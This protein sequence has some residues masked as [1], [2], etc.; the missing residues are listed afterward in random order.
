MKRRLVL[1]IFLSSTLALLSCS[2]QRL[3]REYGSRVAPAYLTHRNSS[4]S[5]ALMA[6]GKISLSGNVAVDGLQSFQGKDSE[7]FLHTN[8]PQAEAI[9]WT[10]AQPT[11]QLAVS[12]ALSLA[13]AGRPALP[14]ALKVV[15]KA[16]PLEFLGIQVATAVTAKAESPALTLSPPRT[17]VPGGV[18]YLDNPPPYEGVLVLEDGAELYIN[19]AFHC[20]GTIVGQGTVYVAGDLSLKGSSE[21]TSANRVALLCSGDLL[22]EGFEGTSFLKKIEKAKRPLEVLDKLFSELEYLTD[23]PQF[24]PPSTI[25]DIPEKVIPPGDASSGIFGNWGALDRINHQLYNPDIA[26]IYDTRLD[27]GVLP[28]LE[29]LLEIREPSPERDFALAKVHTLGRFFWYLPDHPTKVTAL[30]DFRAVPRSTKVGGVD[31]VYDVIDP[32]KKEDFALALVVR[33]IAK[34]HHSAWIGHAVFEGFLYSNGNITVDKEMIVHG[35]AMADGDIQLRDAKVTY[36]ADM[37][38]EG[39]GLLH[40]FHPR[41]STSTAPQTLQTPEAAQSSESAS[42]AP[43]SPSSPKAKAPETDPS[44]PQ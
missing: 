34:D 14:P 3:D 41:A 9:S 33:N 13:S 20:Q 21:I 28:E 18:Y 17:I 42:S 44:A 15:E 8:S 6:G 16:S 24:A 39:P 38:A 1:L 12:G 37:F 26:I 22:L 36:F 31:A 43:Q 10:Q 25:P 23:H 27:Q 19:G 5:G 30:E 32:E 35:A 7:T 40:L 2:P 4:V 11:D 29:K